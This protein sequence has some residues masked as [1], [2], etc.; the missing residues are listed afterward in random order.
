M[1]IATGS[2]ARALPGAPFDEAKVLSNDG[3][4]RIGGVPKTLGVIGSGV[5]GLEMGSVWRRL[6]AQV[7]ILEALP[8]FLGAADESI[9]KEAAKVFA[10]QNLKIELGVK[11][12]QGR[13]QR[14]RR[15]R[16]PTPTP[17]ARSRCWPSTS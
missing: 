14:R 16:R 8:A 5:I 1:I 9:A 15:R 17:R 12:D 3:A 6:G 2:N 11:V 4:L 10:K 7:T 13:H